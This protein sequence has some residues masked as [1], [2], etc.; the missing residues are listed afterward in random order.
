MRSLFQGLVVCSLL[1]SGG[2]AVNA[3]RFDYP[4]NGASDYIQGLGYN[5]QYS[6][7]YVDDSNNEN[8]N[9]AD[10][11]EENND[12][13]CMSPVGTWKNVSDVG[14]YYF[15]RTGLHPAEDWN[16]VTGTD[17]NTEVQA[18]ANGEIIEV[19]AVAGNS[20]SHGWKIIIKHTADD[21][22]TFKYPSSDPSIED[23]N[24]TEIGNTVYSVYLHV[25]DQNSGDNEM[26][27]PNLELNTFVN[28][29]D[30]IGQIANTNP[31]HLHLEIR[32][33]SVYNGGALYP[34]SNG[35]GYYENFENLRNDGVLDPSDFIKA[36]RIVTPAE[37]IYSCPSELPFNDIEITDSAICFVKDQWIV[38]GYDDGTY[39]PNNPITRAEF[40][41]IILFADLASKHTLT[42]NEEDNK[43]LISMPTIKDSEYF[44]DILK[45]D[46]SWYTKYVYHA[47]YD[48]GENPIINGYDDNTFKPMSNIN[49]AEV[50]KI[51][52]NTFLNKNETTSI[53]NYPIECAENRALNEWFNVNILALEEK[54]ITALCPKKDITRA[55]MAKIIYAILK[56]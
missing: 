6:P 43:E 31:S 33:G 23:F 53:P 12:N 28:R 55:E 11:C 35:N 49:F 14:N 17:V 40:L 4:M 20:A 5:Q 32:D 1:I 13:T 26:S 30:P 34:N 15:P 42:D 7:Y 52:N 54:G 37:P 48:Y 45:R 56:D 51:V 29:G 44:S 8:Y 3:D 9:R 25:K 21:N 24:L 39:K 47:K 27:V 22:N 50:A 36:N 46:D 10:I 16:L 38:N 19:S 41:K 18:I 2:Y